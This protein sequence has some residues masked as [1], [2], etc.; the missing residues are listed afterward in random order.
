SLAASV[1]FYASSRD[2]GSPATS[3]PRSAAGPGA[4]PT[5]RSVPAPWHPA[6]LGAAPA[7]WLPARGRSCA[8]RPESACA[9]TTPSPAAGR[10]SASPLR[11]SHRSAGRLLAW[12]DRRPPPGQYARVGRSNRR[13]CPH[14][15]T[16]S[17]P[18]LLSCKL[19]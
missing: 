10:C 14:Y 2:G 5:R 9:P 6:P 8:D 3:S 1:F 7:E 13:A 16:L 12:A 15:P 18:C 11:H 4:P 19:L 17:V